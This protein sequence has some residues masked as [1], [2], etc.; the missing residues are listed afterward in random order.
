[1]T[2]SLIH[3]LHHLQYNILN[4]FVKCR[5]NL[6]H[7]VNQRS[8]DSMTGKSKIIEAINNPFTAMYMR[9]YIEAKINN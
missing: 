4:H 3:I 7:S 5:S 2:R 9:K 1:M 6:I 8:T